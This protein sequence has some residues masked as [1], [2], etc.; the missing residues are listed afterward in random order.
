MKSI[1]YT[2]QGLTLFVDF[3]GI[4][5]S[6]F[7][8]SWFDSA[9]VKFLVHLCRS[10][11]T[12]LVL[13]LLLLVFLFYFIPFTY[14]YLKTASRFHRVFVGCV[15]IVAIGISAPIAMQLAKARYF[16]FNNNILN[17]HASFAAIEAGINY[18]KAGDLRSAESEFNLVSTFSQSGRCNDL[19]NRYIREIQTRIHISDFIYTRCIS[20]DSSLDDKLQRLYTCYKLYPT[21]YESMYI[22]LRYGIDEAIQH[23]PQLY[24][25]I[26]VN[27]YDTCKRLI[28]LYGYCWFEQRVFERLQHDNRDF[29]LRLLHQY[30][31]NEDCMLGQSRLIKKYKTE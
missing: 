12:E 13:G 25:A 30:I 3:F 24:Q 15:V 9:N 26:T 20:R 5:I 21:K 27:D 7:S 22:E 19:A 31:A 6:L 23:Y 16:Y 8:E 18:L 14:N 28:A 11:R 4:I 17:S 1:K 10:F 2:I 29:I